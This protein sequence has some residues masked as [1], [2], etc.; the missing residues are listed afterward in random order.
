[1]VSNE[2]YVDISWNVTRSFVIKGVKGQLRLHF[3]NSD[4]KVDKG[5]FRS[6]PLAAPFVDF[7]KAFIRYRHATAPVSYS[8]AN[9]RVFGLRCV[10]AAF[11]DFGHPPEIWHLAPVI[12]N[13]A[14]ELGTTGKAPS[15]AYKVASEIENLYDFCVEMQLLTD[16]FTWR[17]GVPYPG[18][19]SIKVGAR[20]S[21]EKPPWSNTLHAIGEI[22]RASPTWADQIYSRVAALLV[23]FPIRAHEL[24]QLRVNP[25]IEVAGRGEDGEHRTDF[26]LQI[27]PGKGDPPQVKWVLNPGYTSLARQAV[28]TLREMLG[29][30]REL[31]RWYEY[32]PS[33]L[34]LPPHLDHLRRAEW[35]V[36]SE[37]QDII[38]FSRTAAHQWIDDSGIAKRVGA[39]RV[40]GGRGH[41]RDLI[42]VRFGD[43]ER[44]ILSLLPKD[45]PY[46]NGDKRGHRYSEA[47]L[48]APVNALHTSRNPWKCMFEAIG[49]EQFYGWMRERVKVGLPAAG[50]T[51]LRSVRGERRG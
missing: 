38:G 29:P 22:L 8:A 35:L 34:Y 6:E 5:G 16:A 48:V 11:R 43:V 10:E 4:A 40:V 26:G 21:T 18:K 50:E 20:R 19:R 42:E 9:R 24:L 41:G 51:E 3:V 15:T 28:Q 13:R 46:V 32:N 27:W 47:L 31:A 7:A 33:R 2:N 14:V 45:F 17:H 44:A 39:R 1:L 36:V 23:A 30:A 37:V 25:E 49:Y 12:L